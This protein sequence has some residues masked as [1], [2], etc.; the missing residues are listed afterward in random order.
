MDSKTIELHRLRRLTA[1]SVEAIELISSGKRD[2]DTADRL[3]N[4]LQLFKENRLG[5]VLPV[6]DSRA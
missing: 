5:T 1:L 3:V 4:A 6:R 2:E